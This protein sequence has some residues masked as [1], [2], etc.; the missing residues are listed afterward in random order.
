MLKVAFKESLRVMAAANALSTLVGVPVCWAIL[1]L[2]T[3]VFYSVGMDI[4]ASEHIY[5]PY[6]SAI[7]LATWLPPFYSN[8]EF[9]VVISIAQL[10]LLIPFFFASWGVEYLV[11]KSMLP[12]APRLQ[13]RKAIGRGNLYTYLMLAIFWAFLITEGAWIEKV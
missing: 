9:S 8:A 13:L 2:P 5:A 3:M 6:L 4:L 1:V 12:G 10:V 11:A 7:V